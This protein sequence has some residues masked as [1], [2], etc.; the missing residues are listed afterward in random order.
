MSIQ[1]YIVVFFFSHTFLKQAMGGSSGNQNNVDMYFPRRHFV[2]RT[3]IG[4][5][6]SRAEFGAFINCD[7]KGLMRE[8]KHIFWMIPS[9]YVQ[10]IKP[11]G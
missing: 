2:C 10:Q 3:A 6:W 8:F 1:K 4:F 7:L 9:R 11:F 5:C